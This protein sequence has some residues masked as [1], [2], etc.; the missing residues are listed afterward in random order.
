MKTVN[1]IEAIDLIRNTSGKVFSVIFEKKDGT[2]RKMNCRLGVKKNLKGTGMKY[3]PISKGLITVYDM[4][5]KGYRMINIETL[6]AI[7]VNGSVYTV[8]EK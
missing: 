2:D 6:R 4:H 7:Q 1:R 3:D 5:K 8:F